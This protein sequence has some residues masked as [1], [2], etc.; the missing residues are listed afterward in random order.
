MKLRVKPRSPGELPL[1]A[2]LFAPLFWLPL[3]AWL[4]ET[5]TI[6]LAQCG[7]KR[8]FDTPCASCGSTRA[9]V[10]LFHGNVETAFTFQPLMMTLYLFIAGWGML[11]LW[12]LVTD[13]SLELD[14][15]RREDI[16]A[17]VSLVALPVINWAYLIHAGI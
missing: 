4:V 8:L 15:S 5:K 14:L 12:A 1:G 9:T 13:N 6:E 3:G 2:L 16:A 10:H 17:K 11:S 7:L